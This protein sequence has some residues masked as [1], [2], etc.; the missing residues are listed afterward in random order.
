MFQDAAS[1]VYYKEYSPAVSAENAAMLAQKNDFNTHKGGFTMNAPTYMIVI[2]WNKM[3]LSKT[4]Q[5]P[6][7]VG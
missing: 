5:V 3:E 6:S 2:T 7:Q 1:G 4:P